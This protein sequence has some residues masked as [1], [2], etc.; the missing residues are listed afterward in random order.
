MK[1]FLLLAVELAKGGFVFRIGRGV[2][3]E[4]QTRDGG[5]EG[6]A[7]GGE[8]EFV[9]DRMYDC[10]YVVVMRRRHPLA[11][12]PEL[13]LDLAEGG[14]LDPRPRRGVRR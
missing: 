2:F 6:A 10:E 1:N 8:S 9:L 3:P 12:R 4:G 5:G 7:A 14:A 13:T 11:S